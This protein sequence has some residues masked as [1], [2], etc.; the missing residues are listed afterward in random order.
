MYTYSYRYNYI[1]RKKVYAI[2]YL[3]IYNYLIEK[4]QHLSKHMFK[5]VR[6]YRCIHGIS[7]KHSK[8]RFM[9]L[10][11]PKLPNFF[12]GYIFPVDISENYTFEQLF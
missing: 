9:I 8:Y 12:S 6:I 11:T 10:N 7:Q 1:K 4:G 2:T 3:C 5:Y